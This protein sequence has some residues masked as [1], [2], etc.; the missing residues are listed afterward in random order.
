MRPTLNL[1]HCLA[2]LRACDTRPRTAHEIMRL[3]GMSRPTL[4]RTL[5]DLREQLRAEV[6]CVDGRYQVGDWGLIE[7]S[8]A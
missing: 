3:T 8:R 4:Y 2:I 1:H 5:A 6:R 7:R